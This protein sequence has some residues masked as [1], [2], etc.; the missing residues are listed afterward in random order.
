VDCLDDQTAAEFV[1]GALSPEAAEAVEIHIDTCEDCR[2]VISVLASALPEITPPTHAENGAHDRADGARLAPGAKIG[3]FTVL[4]R[5][6]AGGMGIVYLVHDPELDRRIAVKLL[7]SEVT[8]GEARGRLAREAQAMARLSHRNVLAVHDI[9]TDGDRMFIALELIEGMSLTRWLQRARPWREIVS[10]FC[11]AGSG[12]AAAHA[13][14]IVHR[15][16][17]PDN[18]LVANDGRV[19]VSDFGLA[20]AASDVHRSAATM[21]S[22]PLE[23]PDFAADA[24]TYGVLIESQLTR[25]GAVLGTPSYMAPEQLAGQRSDARSD[26]FSFCVAL[27]EALH[28]QHPFGN[29]SWDE[30]TAAVAAGRI[31]PV[32]RDS[33]VPERLRRVLRVGLS[34]DPERRYPSMDALIVAVRRVQRRRSRTIA[35]GVGAVAIAAIG[36]TVLTARGG[37]SAPP[38]PDPGPKLAG[39]WSAARELRIHIAFLATGLPYAEDAW[40]GVAAQLDDYAHGWAAM[41]LD[42][43][44]ATEI[45]HEQSSLL[46]DRRMACLDER[47]A[48][49]AALIDVF[50]TGQRDVVRNAVSAAGQLPVL[51]ACADREHLSRTTEPEDPITRSAIASIERRLAAADA[52]G[53]TGQLGAALA[54]VRPLA[55]EAERTGYRSLQARVGYVLGQLQAR[56]DDRVGAKRTFEAAMLAGEAG[57]DDVAVAFSAMAVLDLVGYQDRQ[58]AAGERALERAEATVERIGHV[59]YVEM[60]FQQVVGNFRLVQ[61]RNE[62]ARAA[63]DK[64]LGLARKNL[65]AN[66]MVT[67]ELLSS[68]GAPYQEL[69]QAEQALARYREALA[70][71]ERL[72]G[73]WHPDV[74]ASLLHVGIALTMLGKHREAVAAFE[75]GAAIASRTLGDRSLAFAAIEGE[76]GNAYRELGDGDRAEQAFR[77]A[78]AI[79]EDVLGPDHPD[80]ANLLSQYAVLLGAVEKLD[81]QVIV[82]RRALAIAEKAGDPKADSL[83]LNL[84]NALHDEGQDDAALPYERRALAA[85]QQRLGP[86]HRDVAVAYLSLSTVLR[87]QGNL[88]EAL[89]AVK[90]AIAIADKVLAP[91]HP[92]LTAAR[93]EL[94]RVLVRLGRGHLAQAP[95]ERALASNQADATTFPRDLAENRF[96]LAQALWVDGNRVRARE[97]ATAARAGYASVNS[98]PAPK[99]VAAVDAWLQRHH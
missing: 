22:D 75:R 39:V 56:S 16:F 55:V 15:D 35:I 9:G 43:C 45:R 4:E 36:F 82:A 41:R 62:E 65:G 58:L 23:R 87:T 38:C 64:A 76:L 68:T 24:K 2:R 26:Q 14:G 27:W 28:H 60:A 19:C 33:R 40:R 79:T 1:R 93:V 46:L 71:R 95:L 47:L 98:P 59:D 66:S 50:E 32:P 69:G 80:L 6:G 11:E 73:P 57:R 94:G 72:L 70:I 5:L 61:G 97:L 7:R 90:R 31:A 3:R 51:V 92:M 99:D 78:I 53:D 48:S 74:S 89:S 13:A 96:L 25:S 30:L 44:E 77:R 52:L 86:E 49:L 88:E 17:K 54:A 37:R 20:R 29:R 84:G 8:D 67:A 34:V 91:D 18:V 21:T 10:A 83:L 12:L 63:Y 42:A 81:Q 85:M